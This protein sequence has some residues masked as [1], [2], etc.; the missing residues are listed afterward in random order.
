MTLQLPSFPVL[1]LSGRLLAPVLAAFY[2]KHGAGK[3]PDEITAI[4]KKCSELGR[5]ADCQGS[6]AADLVSKLNLKYGDRPDGYV[7]T[8]QPPLAAENEL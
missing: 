8:F 7:S 5:T 4:L 1:R 6:M 2:E 3:T